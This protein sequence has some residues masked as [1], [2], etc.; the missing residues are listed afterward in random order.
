LSFFYPTILQISRTLSGS[1]I[2]SKDNFCDLALFISS[3]CCI[4][5]D[6]FIRPTGTKETAFILIIF[7]PWIGPIS[8][9]FSVYQ[10][11]YGFY[12][13]NFQPLPAA[14]SNAN[15]APPKANPASTKAKSSTI[16]SE[17]RQLNGMHDYEL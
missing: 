10:A 1:P 2:P 17:V 8:N 15:P 7:F 12:Y 5:R 4:Q 3:A 6:N 13:E 14:N 16:G 9:P 11:N